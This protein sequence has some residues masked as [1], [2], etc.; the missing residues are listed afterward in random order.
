MH[1]LQ[2]DRDGRRRQVRMRGFEF[3][4]RRVSLDSHGVKHQVSPFHRAGW[5][6][7]RGQ[8]QIWA[9]S[10]G[11]SAVMRAKLLKDVGDVPDHSS[12]TD[13]EGAGDLTVAVAP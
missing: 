8:A 9:D 10:G 11:L 6:L 1:H 13:G 7:R 12:L 4:G 3:P 2:L 5:L